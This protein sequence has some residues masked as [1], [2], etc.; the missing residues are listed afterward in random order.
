MYFVLGIVLMVAVFSSATFTVLHVSSHDTM[1][2]CCDV[3]LICL[4]HVV[5]F[6]ISLKIT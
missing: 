6:I 2:S 3:F 1:L 5:L 4:K